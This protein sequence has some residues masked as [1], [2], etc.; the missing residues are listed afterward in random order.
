MLNI[1]PFANGDRER[2]DGE[3]CSRCIHTHTHNEHDAHCTFRSM[4]DLSHISTCLHC[5]R[6]E[7]YIASHF[8]TGYKCIHNSIYVH[9]D[10]LS[11]HH[12]LHAMP[13]SAV[14]ARTL[15]FAL[16]NRNLRLAGN[17]NK[18]CASVFALDTS[19]HIW[20]GWYIKVNE[21][22][23]DNSNTNNNNKKPATKGFDEFNELHMQFA[24]NKKCQACCLLLQKIHTKIHRAQ[25]ASVP[26]IFPLHMHFWLYPAA[27]I[28]ANFSFFPALFRRFLLLVPSFLFIRVV[29]LFRYL[30]VCFVC[31]FMGAVFFC[32]VRRNYCLFLCIIQ[33][34]PQCFCWLGWNIFGYE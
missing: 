15:A 10:A 19:L 4:H 9:A 12:T 18:R 5:H 14:G 30:Q 32:L 13:I 1:G 23:D 3:R 7:H 6:T 16:L 34:A 8:S 24:T 26:F 22:V 11:N 2:E 31:I 33:P 20:C 29:C 27:E 17:A 21:R 25:S 28:Y